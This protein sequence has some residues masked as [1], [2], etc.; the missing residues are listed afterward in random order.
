VSVAIIDVVTDKDFNLYAQLLEFI[1]EADPTFGAEPPAI[2][3]AVCR[4][5]P[6]SGKHVLE[7]W[8]YTLQL[9]QRLPTLPLWLTETFAVPLD[10]ETT[11]EKT[12]RALRIA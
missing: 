8:S 9:G 5:I 3:A 1:G 6:R 7:T 2:S 12:C 4:W 11:Y 10:L